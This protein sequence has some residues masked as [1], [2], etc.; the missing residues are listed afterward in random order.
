MNESPRAP[1]V[2]VLLPVRDAADTLPEAME[3]LLGQTFTNFEVV[4]VDD[5]STDGTAEQLESFAGR[6]RRVRVLRGPARGLVATLNRGFAACRG[7]LVARMDA[8]D[9]AS[10]E[11]LEAQ[12][13]LLRTRPELGLVGCLVEGAGIDGT[14]LR[15]GMARY[16]TWQNELVSPEEIARARFIESPLVHPTVLARRE[17]LLEAVGYL[18]YAWPEDY[19]LWLR[20]LGAGVRMAKVPR[21]LLLWRDHQARATRTLPSYGTDRI[22][23]LKVHHLLAGPLAS[24][25]PVVFWGAGLEGKPLLR[26]LRSRGVAIPAVVE[27][28]PRKIGNVIHGARAIPV[29]ELRMTLAAHPGAL[30]LVAVGVP[31]AR[32]L[33][34][35]ELQAHGLEEGEDAFFLC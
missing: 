12:V 6:D 34:R 20:L 8:D 4:A 32:P 2:S 29:S 23:A 5:G 30:V 33:I 18:D 14:P 7:A 15:P 3:S 10:P 35:E 26:A 11:R 19:D 22:R 25:R 9:V 24:G 16:I 31:E 17:V 13:G 28:D 1:D 27:A 21:P